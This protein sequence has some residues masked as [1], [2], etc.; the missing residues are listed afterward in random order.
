L[1]E[2]HSRKGL[3]MPSEKEPKWL[4]WARKLQAVAQNGLTFTQ[5]SYDRER[6]E[7]LRRVAAE[8][9]SAGCDSE[10]GHIEGLFSGEVGYAT[11]KVDVRAAVFRSDSL[12]L[13]REASDGCWTLPGG[14]ADVNES[15]SESVVREV[16]EESGF[17][18]RAEKLLAVYDRSRHPHIPPFPYHCYK[19]IF[20][21]SIIGETAL[22]KGEILEAGF[23]AEE[24]IPELSM[25]R[26]TPG[27]I[28]RVFEHY[29]HPDWPTDFD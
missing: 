20:R 4:L 24:G 9:M 2:K 13:V 17:E 22:E 8:M 7:Q 18:T 25:T 6:Y 15:P 1:L 10:A 29:R 16:L 21:C 28:R 11:P 12:L 14:W 26:V 3:S 5:D 23:F 27:Q 19:L